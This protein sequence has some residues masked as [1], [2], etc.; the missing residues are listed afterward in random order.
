MKFY[1]YRFGDLVFVSGQVPI[2]D[3]EI[4]E[5]GI[6]NETVVC[7]EKIGE[8]LQEAGTD[9]SRA[10]KVIVYLQGAF[11]LSERESSTSSKLTVQPQTSMTTLT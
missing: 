2:V 10:L 4:V 9:W 11:A 3:G 1:T 7:L 8:V 6:K 5:G